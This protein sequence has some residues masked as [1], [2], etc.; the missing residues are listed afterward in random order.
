M[1]KR[2]RRTF[3]SCWTCRQ[4]RVTCD[5][6]RPTCSPCRI[7]GISCEGYD[8]RLVWVNMLTG[9]Y[10][11]HSRR[12]LDAS[13]T[14][15]DEQ[16][17]NS[18]ELMHLTAN[19]TTCRCKL[20]LGKG[21]PNPFKS[22]AHIPSSLKRASRLD[23]PC[24]IAP[25]LTNFNNQGAG[26]AYLFDHYINHVAYLMVPIRTMSNPW[27]STYPSIAV[28]ASSPLARSLYHGLLSQAAFN[29]AAL[30]SN[31]LGR[32]HNLYASGLEHYGLALARLREG[33]GDPNSDAC[34]AVAA[35]LTLINI[36]VHD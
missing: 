30:T 13:Q 19:D 21:K 34:A 2:T 9:E 10:P 25:A 23:Y 14:W 7:R 28:Q 35:L 31:Q 33:L 17:L 36:E 5:S 4:R 22:F 15:L 32:D 20:H 3:N 1:A 27:R 6:R 18:H 24:R 8:I 12:S 11:T 26:N 16:T 29:L